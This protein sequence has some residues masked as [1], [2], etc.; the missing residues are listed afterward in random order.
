MARAEVEKMVADV[1]AAVALRN[2]AMHTMHHA[3]LKVQGIVRARRALRVRRNAMRRLEAALTIQCTMRSRLAQ[4]MLH[5]MLK[6]GAHHARVKVA[7]ELAQQL[8]TTLAKRHVGGSSNHRAAVSLAPYERARQAERLKRVHETRSRIRSVAALRTG[9]ALAPRLPR[10]ALPARLRPPSSVT[11]MGTPP[12][13]ESTATVLDSRLPQ[14]ASIG[15]RSDGAPAGAA[16][17]LRAAL[18]AQSGATSAK[19]RR[20]SGRS[21]APTTEAESCGQPDARSLSSAASAAPSVAPSAPAPLA[22]TNAP[23]GSPVS[24]AG[25]PLL[26]SFLHSFVCTFILCSSTLFSSD[27]APR[28][29]RV[30]R[31]IRAMMLPTK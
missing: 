19:P 10:S 4:R 21:L 3:V 18:G 11:P 2:T 9:A 14:D 27:R 26:L 17:T 28:S 31:R 1:E 20:R 6:T 25:T 23:L 29:Q 12:R 30:P 22:R 5:S 15:D 7:R 8:A 16:A 13:R 24:C